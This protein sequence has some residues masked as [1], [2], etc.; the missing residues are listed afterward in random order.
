MDPMRVIEQ[1]AARDGFPFEAVR[2]ARANRETMVPVFL[3]TID[4]FLASEGP[5][6]PNAL[7]L[8]FH[9]FGE[10]RE[11]SA[12]RS[13]AALL[14]LPD[15]VVGLILGDFI[16]ETIHRVMADVFDGDPEPLY[17]IIRDPEADEVVRAKMC[18][19]VAILT[20][21]GQMQRDATL[22][23]LRDCFEQLE[24]QKDCYVWSGWVDAVAW[25]GATELKPLVQLLFRRG[26]VDPKWRKLRNFE[27][28]IQYAIEHPDAE[29][30]H[31]GGGDLTPFG[32]TVAEL[33]ESAAFEPDAPDNDTSEWAPPASLGPPHREP[34]RK[35]GRNDPCPCGSGKKFKKC[36]LNAAA[37]PLSESAP[38]W[39]TAAP[40]VRNR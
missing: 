17:G 29:L 7:A 4:D 21:R 16:T 15:D 25:L 6:D 22:A 28:D 12:Y 31:I 32:D 39:E 33:S 23:F 38:P 13:L 19:T 37:D 14:R 11:K 3:R 20:R 30:R 40:Y 2:V 1:L 34:S 18:Q 9:L 8:M 26:S 5:A 35:I 10:W 27:E 24:P 36:C